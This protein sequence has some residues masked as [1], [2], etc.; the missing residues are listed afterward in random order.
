MYLRSTARRQTSRAQAR[1]ECTDSIFS[2]DPFSYERVLW[3]DDGSYA[4]GVRLR[5]V[6]LNRLPALVASAV[7]LRWNG[8]TP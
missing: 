5:S 2:I 8:D 6:A 7:A 4:A 1:T 3:G